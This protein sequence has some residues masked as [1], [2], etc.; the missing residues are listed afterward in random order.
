MVLTINDKIVEPEFDTVPEQMQKL[1]NWVVWKTSPSKKVNENGE[2]I[3]DKVL[4]RTNGSSASSTDPKTW[5]DFHTAYSSYANGKF[6]GIGFVFQ[7]ENRIIGL[8][9]DGHF[10]DGEPLT[11]IAEKICDETF[12]E[13]SP[14]GTGAHAYFIGDMPEDFKKKYSDNEG[15]LEIYNDGRFFT[16]TGVQVGQGN[17]SKNQGFINDLVKQYFYKAP[18]NEIKFEE[19]RQPNLFPSNEIKRKMFRNE[20]LKKLFDGDLSEYDNDASAA[21]MALCNHL[22]FWTGKNPNQMDEIFRES[23][24]NREKWDKVHSSNGDTYGEMTIKEAI[25]TCRNVYKQSVENPKESKDYVWDD[26]VTFDNDEVLPFPKNIFPDWV[27]DYIDQVALSTQTPREMAAMGAFT[28]LSIATAKKFNIIVYDSWIEPLNTYLLTLMPPASRK[29]QVFKDMIKPITDYQKERR[30]MLKHEIARNKHELDIKERKIVGLKKR[31]SEPKRG[32]NINELEEELR[33]EIDALEDMEEL[34]EPT[35]VADDVT[36]EVLE[37][38]LKDNNERMA[39]VSPEGGM[40]SN[41]SRYSDVANLDVFLKGHPAERLTSHRLSREAVE[42]EE[43][44]LTVGIFAQPTVIQEVPEQFFKKGL[45]ARFLFSLPTDNRGERQIRPRGKDPHTEKTYYNNLKSLM[46]I[47]TDGINLTLSRTADMHVQLLQEEIEMRQGYK[48]DL[49]ENEEIESWAGKL[50]GQLMRLAG[51]IHMS[52]ALSHS[53]YIVQD[54]TITAIDKLKDYFISHAKKAFSVSAVDEDIEDAAYL[55]GRI[56]E[57]HEDG[58][59]KRQAL[60][61]MVKGRFGK[62][63]LFE[64]PLNHLVDRGYVKVVDVSSK[65]GRGPK[66]KYVVLNPAMQL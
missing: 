37:R 66:T 34:K 63:T 54:D 42:L 24:L 44:H 7:K 3:L 38:L 22:A 4:K 27:E 60:W 62:A 41:M 1:N 14:S 45:M 49:R 21:D 50:V 55:L 11:D 25:N 18:E 57:L 26:I 51:L 8:D 30:E 15:E 19:A 64:P 58:S 28:A 43:P 17:I 2:Q 23:A 36:S 47:Q 9:L 39:I 56:L 48:E 5:T 65:S 29:S 12:V 40:F 6:S 59:I 10:E 16:F 35:Y 31:I 53:D 13:I 20:K 52:K 32:D 33:F 46:N 61:Q